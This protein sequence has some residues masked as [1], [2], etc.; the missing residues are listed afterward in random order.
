VQTYVSRL[1][2]QLGHARLVTRP[3][4]YELRIDDDELDLAR[5][6]RLREAARGQTAATAVRT[7]REGLAMWRGPPFADLAYEPFAAAVVARLDDLRLLTL[8]QLFDA[9]L[10]AGR[11]AEVCGEIELEIAAHPHRERLRSQLMLALYR[12]G[13]QADALDAY[14]DARRTLTEELGIEPGRALR[15]L[16]AAVLRQDPAL[17]APQ[18][19]SSAPV[20]VGRR[21]S[22]SG[23]AGRR[24]A[25]RRTG[26]GSR[27]CAAWWRSTIQGRCGPW[28]ARPPQSSRRSFPS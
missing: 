7:L 6:E 2:T 23:A 21:T 8:E 12:C 20:A 9:E 1:R 14:R 26:R 5:F 3:P 24:A 28:S 27:S 13:R 19:P 4:G 18:Q 15:D 10:E 25:H 17:D 16:Q 22:R 11:H